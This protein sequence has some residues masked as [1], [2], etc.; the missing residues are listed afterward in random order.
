M[1]QGTL[2]SV[3]KVAYRRDPVHSAGHIQEGCGH[4]T[5]DRPQHW[6]GVVGEVGLEPTISCSQSTCVANYATPRRFRAQE[7]HMLPGSGC[8]SLAYSAL[9]EYAGRP[10]KISLGPLTAEIV[11]I[12]GIIGPCSLST[13]TARER[14]FHGSAP[15]AGAPEEPLRI[16]DDQRVLPTA[17]SAPCQDGSVNAPCPCQV[18]KRRFRRGNDQALTPLLNSAATTQPSAARCP[19]RTFRVRRRQ[20]FQTDRALGGAQS[21]P[22]YTPVTDRSKCGP[23]GPIAHPN[24]ADGTRH[25]RSTNAGPLRHNHQGRTN[26]RHLSSWRHQQS[27]DRRRNAGRLRASLRKQ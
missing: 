24:A 27:A 22:V 1:P 15:R 25:C 11:P 5:R 10:P 4:V 26:G 2:S 14:P 9:I 3:R 12:A 6:A 17:S 16:G 23:T 19:D 18:R 20:C 8:P 21:R 13:D 7:P